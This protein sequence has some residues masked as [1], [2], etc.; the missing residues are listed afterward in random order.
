MM[1]QNSGGSIAATPTSSGTSLSGGS[2]QHVDGILRQLDEER[3]TLEDACAE[4]EVRLDSQLQLR[5]FERDAIE[6]AACKFC[7]SGTNNDN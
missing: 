2:I 6:V 1:D 7:E 3:A 5:S 4:R